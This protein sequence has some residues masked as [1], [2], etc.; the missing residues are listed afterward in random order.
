[1]AEQTTTAPD[2]LTFRER[3]KS[4]FSGWFNPGNADS[5]HSASR[6]AGATVRLFAGLQPQL[7]AAAVRPDPFAQLRLFADNCYLMRVVIEKMKDRICAKSWHFRLKPQPGEYV[8]DQ[9][10]LEQRPA[11]R[12]AHAVLPVSGQRPL[13]EEVGAHDS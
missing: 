10:A 13:V 4:T 3:L 6:N 8:S 12:A 9:R 11:H 2:R 1:M 7:D 5:G